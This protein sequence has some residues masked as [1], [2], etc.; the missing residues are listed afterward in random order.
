MPAR[1]STPGGRGGSL[2]PACVFFYTLQK[3]KS[4]SRKIRIFFYRR[5]RKIRIS[6]IRCVSRRRVVCC[7]GS[8]QPRPQPQRCPHV[9]PIGISRVSRHT[10]REEPGDPIRLDVCTYHNQR[11]CSSPTSCARMVNGNTNSTALT[12]SY[13]TPRSAPRY[14]MRDSHASPAVDMFFNPTAA[15]ELQTL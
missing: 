13:T 5:F 11:V 6:I 1:A 15:P 12:K 8:A 7:C 14:I 10:G 2:H 4:E 3:I 9:V